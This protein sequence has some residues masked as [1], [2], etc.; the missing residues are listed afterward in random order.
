MIPPRRDPYLHFRARLQSDLGVDL[1]S[2][3]AM[4]FEALARGESLGPID[5]PLLAPVG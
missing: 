5:H 1:A 3:T 2:D 4:C